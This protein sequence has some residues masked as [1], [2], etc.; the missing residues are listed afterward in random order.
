MRHPNAV[1]LAKRL[2]DSHIKH[3]VISG[4]ESETEHLFKITDEE[5][6]WAEEILA[7]HLDACMKQGIHPDLTEAVAD[8][9]SFAL[10]REKAYEPIPLTA[11]W[12]CAIVVMEER[13]AD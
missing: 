3:Q 7:T 5:L 10:R 11:R 4:I 2:L 13:D 6:A 9:L 12:N 1:S 8:A